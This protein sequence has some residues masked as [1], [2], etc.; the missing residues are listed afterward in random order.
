M[1]R[2][3]KASKKPKGEARQAV[4]KPKSNHTTRQKINQLC[5]KKRSLLMKAY[6]LAHICG[7]QCMVAIYDE[8]LQKYTTFTSDDALEVTDFF[9]YLRDP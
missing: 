8:R 6:K 7:Q 2:K 9:E 4:I 5:K 1:V 3:S